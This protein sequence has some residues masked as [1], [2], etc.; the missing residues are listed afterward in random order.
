MSI[1]LH[2]IGYTLVTRYSTRTAIVSVFVT[3]LI[4]LIVL[5]VGGISLYRK[6]VPLF[7][8]MIVDYTFALTVSKVV[9]LIWF[10]GQAHNLYWGDREAAVSVQSSGNRKIGQILS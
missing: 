5:Q 4:K 6:G 3:W 10:P 7:L 8:G 1:P 2:P 9:D